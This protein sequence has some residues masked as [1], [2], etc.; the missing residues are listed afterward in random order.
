MQDGLYNINKQ[1][2]YLLFLCY[3]LHGDIMAKK[4]TSQEYDVL[5]ER[6]VNRI[7]KANT[8]FLKEVGTSIKEIKMLTPTEAHKLVQSLKYGEKYNQIVK[9]IARYTNMNVKDIDKIFKEYAKKDLAFSKQFYEYRKIP[10]TKYEQNIE[11][12]RQ[13]EA[14]SNLVKN[15]MYDFTR[16][17]VIGYTI[18][19][20]KN[21]IIFKGLKEVYNDLLDQALIN[22]GIGDES[23]DS[24][25]ARIMKQ[26]GKSGLK[27]VNYES[28]R[29]V[30]LD[31]VVR[32]HLNSR[33][34]ELH[35]ENQRLMG[36]QFGADGIEITVHDNPA[37]DH[38]PVQGHQFSNIK[39][40]KNEYSEWEKLQNGEDAKDVN[41]KTFNLDDDGKNGYRPIGELNCYHLYYEIVL[42][43]SE[44]EYTEEQLQKIIDNNNKEFEFDGK[45]YKNMYEVTQLQR[46]METEIRKQ[47][48]IQT[49]A[50]ASNNE[51]LIAESEENINK[52]TSKYFELSKKS[53]LPTKIERLK[54]Y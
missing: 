39:P 47:K 32:M 50:V 16:E 21:N 35:N 18:K 10:Y 51:E 25:M 5:A 37:P 14:L 42:G 19:D 41:G 9:K 29:A 33:L 52:L 43:I 6:L 46:K 34:T 12:K 15:D 45:K 30:R 27:T 40:S 38:A 13:T 4:M 8:Y 36:E 44:P 2:L 28:G 53:G 24:A 54:I 49:L 17:K 3:N 11:L 31:S 26:I 20:R 7:Q 1:I 22:V 23:F 48:D